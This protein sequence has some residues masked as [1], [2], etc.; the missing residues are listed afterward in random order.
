MS[1]YDYYSDKQIIKIVNIIKEQCE[2]A[3]RKENREAIRISRDLYN[4]IKKGRK[5][6]DITADIYVGFF[7]PENV[8]DGIMTQDVANGFYTQP[9][10]VT[11]DSIIHIYHQSNPL[12]SKLIKERLTS[13]KAFFCLRYNVDQLY[14][15]KS[16]EAIYMNEANSEPEFLYI[17]PQI[18]VVA[19]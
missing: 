9:E 4:R 17:K 6:H 5:A 10:L 7:Y 11:K 14:S 12:T 18:A 19:S 8:I 16:I 3:S 2:E 13:G 1:I 15:L